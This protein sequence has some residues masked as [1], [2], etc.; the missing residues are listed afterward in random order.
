[1]KVV[2]SP[3]GPSQ[4][5]DGPRD[6]EPGEEVDSSSEEGEERKKAE[7]GRHLRHQCRRLQVT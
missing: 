4:A 7:G 6:S 1:M 5:E 2:I 3:S